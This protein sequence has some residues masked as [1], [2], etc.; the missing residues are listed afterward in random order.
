[1]T[2]LT[3]FTVETPSDINDIL[4][5]AEALNAAH[6]Y[7]LFY[8][9]ESPENGVSWCPDCVR[10]KPIID[11]VLAKQT[12]SIAFVVAIVQRNEYKGNASYPYRVDPRFELRCIPTL[13]R[14]QDG[15]AV[16][17][18]NDLQCQNEDL[19]EEMFASF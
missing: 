14:W 1:M 10:A 18:L 16:H 19:V 9:A 8:A 6:T 4:Q 3:T 2:S 12:D 13:I 15:K 5:Q 11:S 7:I 17:L